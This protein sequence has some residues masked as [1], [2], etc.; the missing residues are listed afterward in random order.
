MVGGGGGEGVSQMGAALLLDDVDVAVV[1]AE[2]EAVAALG[3]DSLVADS[4][5]TKPI[6]AATSQQTDKEP[7]RSLAVTSSHND[8]PPSPNAP[9]KSPVTTHG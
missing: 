9:A 1:E 3:N 8:P 7:T 4:S 6:E 2:A 5:S